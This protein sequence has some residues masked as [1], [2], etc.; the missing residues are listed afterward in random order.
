MKRV[1]IMISNVLA[2]IFFIW[3]F[4]V[5]ASSFISYIYPSVG[6]IEASHE[7]KFSLVADELAELAESTDSLI[8]I[9]HWELDENGTEEVSYTLFGEGK[10]PEGLQ[11]KV[12][13]DPDTVGI[14]K[15]YFIFGGKLTTQKLKERLSQ[16]GMTR[17]FEIRPSVISVFATVFSNGFQMIGLLI[18]LLTF[19][20]LSLI[21]QIRTLRT[22]GIRMISGENRWTIF[23]KPLWSDMMSMTFGLVIGLMV[24]ILGT[25]IFPFSSPNLI[26]LM[27]ALGLLLYNTL[28]LLIAIFFALL[29]AIG[30]KK[31]HLMKII[32]GQVPVRGILS[33][34]L[35]GQLLAVVII[36]FAINGSFIYSRIWQQQVA[37]QVAWSQEKYLISLHTSREGV[38]LGFDDNASAKG[39]IWYQFINQAVAEDKAFLARHFLVEK[40][41]QATDTK[42]KYMTSLEWDDYSPQGNVLL[43]TPLYLTRQKI[44]VTS[45][46]MDKAHRLQTGEFLLLLPETLKSET[47]H[48]K[49]LFEQSL[50]EQTSLSEAKQDM[51]AT[52]SYLENG[53][54]RFAYNT[55]PISYQQSVKDPIIVVV[56]P[57]SMGENA[58][59]FWE[60]A[61]Y[62]Y[63]YFSDLETT[64]DLIKQHDIVNWVSE[65]KP[66][67]MSYR[68]LLDN[69]QREIWTTFSGAILGVF[70]SILMFN[71]M[72]LLYFEEFRRDV[73]IKR[74]SGYG[75]WGIHKKYLIAQFLVFLLG[76]IVSALITQNGFIS[77][78]VMVIFLLN[79]ILLLAL[80]AKKENAMSTLIL[81]GA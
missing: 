66:A 9:Q 67:Y 24:A 7:V 53:K 70:T 55:T 48:Y 62:Y 75:F 59:A 61:L 27:T 14:K 31:V 49:K 22:A 12:I 50:T 71:T 38:D 25:K 29:F 78:I 79:S 36:G 42:S 46:I 57:Q 19:A 13:T 35:I 63:M 51:S 33:L 77:L 18:F 54:E 68:T 32:K 23:A 47:D 40:M 52:I 21:S 56:T 58:Y 37:G 44:E 65:L 2:S 17:M 10:L 76:S 1:F 73:F 3:L 6:V 72:N 30:I 15:N 28:L 39:K 74:V 4:S 41:M 8:A 20:S 43:V 5:W 60:D 26:I 69:I 16:L 45:D 34:I 64:Q 11:E 80:Q 81:K